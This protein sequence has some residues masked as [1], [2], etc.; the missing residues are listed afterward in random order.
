MVRFRGVIWVF[1]APAGG[2]GSIRTIENPIDDFS[3]SNSQSVKPKDEDGFVYTSIAFFYLI[4]LVV[5]SNWHKRMR[6]TQI[7][8][9]CIAHMYKGDSPPLEWDS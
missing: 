2:T 1:S 4:S 9:S 8:L 5:Q 7:F 6:A 3:L